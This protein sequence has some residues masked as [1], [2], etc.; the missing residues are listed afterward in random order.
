MFTFDQFQ[1]ITPQ[2]GARLLKAAKVSF[3]FLPKG[4]ELQ[5]LLEGKRALSISLN[6]TRF[7]KTLPQVGDYEVTIGYGMTIKPPSTLRV[8]LGGKFDSM[9]ADE[10]I[11][12]LKTPAVEIP[13]LLIF[14]QKPYTTEKAIAGTL[15]IGTVPGREIPVEIDPMDQLDKDSF[16]TMCE[17][18]LGVP[19]GI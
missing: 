6:S 18:V 11:N 15:F 8:G 13:T 4:E 1:D 17:R 19:P 2:A 16:R 10:D 5:V 9:A 12:G 14:V 7:T 3:R